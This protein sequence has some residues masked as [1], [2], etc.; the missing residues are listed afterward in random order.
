M[1]PHASAQTV[2]K[3]MERCNVAPLA[4]VAD[5]AAQSGASLRTNEDKRRAELTPTQEAEH[6]AKRK[7]VWEAM[8]EAEVKETGATCATLADTG[9][10][11][12]QFASETASVTGKDKSTI[13]RAV[14][15]ATEVCQE[16]RDLIR[17]TKLDTGAYLD[18]SRCPST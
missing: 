15:R 13:N 18:R 9:R 17:G 14:R 12:T 1:T 3:Q 6:L 11:N 7:E 4:T 8:R 10:G 2:V 5:R 16:A